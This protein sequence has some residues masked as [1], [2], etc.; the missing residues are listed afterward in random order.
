MVKNKIGFNVLVWSAVMSE[1]LF[2]IVDRLKN[3][4]YDGV[5]CFI[6]EEDTPAYKRFGDYTRSL[7]LGVTAVMVGTKEENPIDKSAIVRKKAI[8]RIRRA[9]DKA[10]DM[11]ASII[12]GPFHSAH[13]SFSHMPPQEEEYAWGAE[14]LYVAGNYAAEANIT[15][16]LEALNRFECYLCNTME[17]LSKLINM[18]DHPNVRAM[19]DTHHANIE[20]K[21]IPQSIYTIAPVLAHVHISENDRGTPG[22]GHVRWDE[23]FSTLAEINYD[24]WLTIEAFSR[25][26]PAF[27]N[28]IGVWRDYSEPWAI[29][30][31]GYKFI[32]EML[33]KYENK[34]PIL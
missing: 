19:Y 27:A 6:G 28:S 3:I 5:E 23:T 34:S 21:K 17:H 14:V 11:N 24:G 4:G 20:E 12:C 29:A 18:A 8:D 1:D 33:D 22:D 7:D 31:Q 26:D 9:I 25:N 16:A 13:S 15:L 10:H 32:K 30:E 2:P